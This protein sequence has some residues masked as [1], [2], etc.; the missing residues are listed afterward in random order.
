MFDFDASAWK[1]QHRL[2]L[3]I[4]IDIYQDDSLHQLKGCGND[5]E[6]MAAVLKDRFEFAVV[7]LRDREATREAILAALTAL[8]EAAKEGDQV[9]LFWSGHGSN[10]KFSDGRTFETLVPS[11]SS[12]GTWEQ[13]QDITDRELFGWV[14]RVSEKTRFL[15][16]ILDACQSGSAVRDAVAQPRGARGETS[17]S[18]AMAQR[19]SAF[20]PFDFAAAGVD[21]DVAGKSRWLPVS[22]L[23]TLLASC[24]G[25]EYCREVT[26]PQTDLRRGVFSLELQHALLRLQ[27]RLTWR[28][29]FDDV[30][31]AVQQRFRS[32]HPQ[33]EGDIDREIFG[34]EEFR[35]SFH[36][37]VKERSENLLTL[38]GGA[39]H[40]VLQGSLWAI[41]PAGHRRLGE[42][43][44]GELRVDKV[45]ATICEGTLVSERIP[46]GV[47]PGCRAFELSR[48]VENRFRVLLEGQANQD[49]ALKK[50]IAESALLVESPHAASADVLIHRLP[51]R[52]RALELEP[53]PQ[54][55]QIERESWAF[56]D[57]ADNQLAPLYPVLEKESRKTVLGT[58]EK[59]AR[60]R[61]LGELAHPDPA[62]S[63][64][65]TVKLR[66]FELSYAGALIRELGQN[67]RLTQGAR[68][69]F[70]LEHKNEKP[71]EVTVIGLGLTGGISQLY[72]VHGRSQ[73]WS[74]GHELPI[75]FAEAEALDLELPEN[76]P[77]PGESFKEAPE[78]LLFLF[79]E[80]AVR[81][82]EMQEQEGFRSGPGRRG[83]NPAHLALRMSRGGVT[84]RDH[85]HIDALA[86]QKEWGL[87]KWRFTLTAERRA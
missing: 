43:V 85:E 74:A 44:L 61:F 87:L 84:M 73:K 78:T 58:L 54:L 49:Q 45:G 13:N 35:P 2:A 75:G 5:V 29:L 56:T 25:D 60:H 53:L 33:L 9:L 24:Q 47:V 17:P 34:I 7:Q 48:P 21:P 72:P 38:S 81:G 65:A 22:K 14:C 76:Y 70:R 30:A 23:Y 68:V 82:L 57:A 6:A 50:G 69:A 66:A 18:G 42:E 32:Q 8:L 37:S 12:R 52:K 11:D 62:I 63:A 77:F 1:D 55:Q 59:L 51:A 36:V 39:A 4:G 71:L 46:S 26:D 86:G 15:T 28:E 64:A 19:K 27:G 3:L 16:L 83:K 67:P 10:L 80:S 20:L 79:T 40:G 31:S 41:T